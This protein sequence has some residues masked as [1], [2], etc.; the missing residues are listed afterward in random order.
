MGGGTPDGAPTGGEKE[1][2]PDGASPS[3][4]PRPQTKNQPSTLTI[5]LPPSLIP[6][7]IP[8]GSITIDGVSL[9]VAAIKKNL[10]E[11]ALIPHTLTHTT[12]GLLK[13]GDFVNIETDVIIRALLHHNLLKPKKSRATLTKKKRL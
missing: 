12:L 2:T 8:K 7:V 13:K 9:T 6:G 3:G 5:K 1:S 10:C 4:A 11:I